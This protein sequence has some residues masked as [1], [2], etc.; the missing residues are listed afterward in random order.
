MAAI[1]VLTENLTTYDLIKKIKRLSHEKR[2]TSLDR[3]KY[4]K[5]NSPDTL[6]SYTRFFSE[7]DWKRQK[8]RS[9]IRFLHLTY[10]FIKGTPYKKV[11]EKVSKENQ[12]LTYYCNKVFNLVEQYIPGEFTLKEVTEWVG[13]YEE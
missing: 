1:Q 2:K 3:Q 8:L 4:K 6:G 9:E 7:S 13:C 11:E 12:L 10:N 5:S